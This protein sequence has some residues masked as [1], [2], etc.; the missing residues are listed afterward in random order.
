ML[1]SN[2]RIKIAINELRKA[3]VAEL[4]LSPQQIIAT[5]TM[6]HHGKISWLIKAITIMSRKRNMLKSFIFL[7]QYG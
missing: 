7:I 6:I 1:I 2:Q 5:G 3:D 4:A